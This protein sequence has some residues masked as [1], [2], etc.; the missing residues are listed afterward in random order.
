MRKNINK[1]AK[2]I[3]ATALSLTMVFGLALNTYADEIPA[4]A[5]SEEV[6]AVSATEEICEEAIDLIT[7]EETGAIV[8][9][10][11]LDDERANEIIEDLENAEDDLEAAGTDLGD[12]KEAMKEAE[13]DVAAADQAADGVGDAITALNGVVDDFND[14]DQ[15]TTGFAEDVITD[16]GIANTS[17]DPNEA[18][19]AKDRAGK[20]LAKA[21]DG[22]TAATEAYD[23]AVAKAGAIEA[24]LA[25]AEADYAAAQIK[26]TE[27]QEK[28]DSAKGNADQA[29]NELAEAKAKAD[30]LKAEVDKLS[31]NKDELEAMQEQ[32]YALMIQYYREVFGNNVAKYY[33]E[34]GSLDLDKCAEA[35][36]ETTINNKAKGASD[37]DMLIG[38]YLMK[39]MVEYMLTNE[40]CTDI[41]VGVEDS[42]LNQK[43][44]AK[45]TGYDV[46]V[47]ES[48]A[49]IP[50]STYGQ[51][52]VVID[53]DRRNK[54]LETV[55]ANDPTDMV[56]YKSGADDGRTNR[57]V[58]TY[59]DEDGNTQTKYFNYVFKSGKAAYKDFTGDN[60][61]EEMKN[62]MVYLALVEE[63]DGKLVTTKTE[64]EYDMSNY[65]ELVAALEQAEEAAQVIADYEAAAEAVKAAEEKAKMLADEIAK[66]SN[67]SADDTAVKA[68]RTEFN[69]AMDE[70][71]AAKDK[72]ATLEEKVEE[73]RKAYAAIDLSRFN[74]QPVNDETDDNAPAGDDA[75]P[76]APAAV[77]PVAVVTTAAPAA[78]AAPTAPAEIEEAAAPEVIE[79]A[80]VVEI[81]EEAAPLAETA[82]KKTPEVKILEEETPLAEKAEKA[83]MWWLWLL[84]V[85][86][87][88]AGYCTY[89]YYEKKKEEE[90]VNAQ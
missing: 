76:A 80:G 58:V 43:N 34:D 40:G 57:F 81:P 84:L 70:V 55:S 16:A 26:V 19:A 50:G 68:L 77:T 29:A 23:D 45:A 90:E 1:T 64:S 2:R 18:V 82:E 86:L 42:S 21:E 46:T 32:Y 88:A 79:E 33:K 11:Q 31:D 83:S 24:K 13:A 20:E 69:K 72:K 12:A 17:N 10:A 75:T 35:I 41:K 8:L 78:P 66:L 52:Q 54:A 47:F 85:L 74:V 14:A 9:V 36:S 38:R 56:Q 60:K 87:A 49:K 22:L 39:Q 6:A 53:K 7:N 71:K 59:K 51:D 89:K 65:N 67:V 30:A 25:T 15:D 44:K 73:A 62:G 27:A 5:E 63:E 28:L 48:D 4:A 3:V 61:T 37:K